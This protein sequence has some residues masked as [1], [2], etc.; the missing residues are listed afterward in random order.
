MTEHI[1]GYDARSGQSEGFWQDVSHALDEGERVSRLDALAGEMRTYYEL[2]QGRG[3]TANQAMQLVEA[4]QS[5]CQIIWY[6]G[7]ECG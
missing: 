4:F 5:T 3:F 2:L 1:P 7:E 6:G